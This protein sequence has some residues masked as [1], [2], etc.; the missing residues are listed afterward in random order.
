MLLPI[1]RY[2]S[3]LVNSV[4][5]NAVTIINAETGS[6]KSTQVCQYLQEAGYEVIVTEPRRIAA[7]TLADRV[8]EEIG[9]LDIV[10]YHT[11]FE[12]EISEKNE[13]LFCTDGLQLVKQL[14]E[15]LPKITRK[16]RVIIID[17]AHEW[18]LNIECLV[19]WAKKKLMEGWNTKIVITSATLEHEDL[20]SYYGNA[21]V[22]SIPGT[23]FPVTVIEAQACELVDQ[24]AMYSNMGKNVLVFLPGKREIEETM[25]EL[26]GK[27]S[28]IILPMH[29]ELTMTDQR[30]CFKEYSNSSKIVLATNIAQTSVTIPDIDVVV[31]SGTERRV[32]TDNGIQGIFLKDIS[33]ADCMQR[34]GRAGRTKNGI[35]VLCGTP[36]KSRDEFSKPEIQRLM[37][38]QM[39]LRLDS[40]G[41]D[42]SEMEFFHQPNPEDIL[43]AKNVLQII[44]AT[45]DNTITELGKKILEIPISVRHARMI[46]E[47]DKYGVVDDVITIAAILEIGSLI[48]HRETS[49][50]ILTSESE[51]D[52][53]AELQIWNTRQGRKIDFKKEG[54]FAK[55]F[56]RVKE[57]REK[58]IQCIEKN[59]TV[60]LGSTGNRKDIIRSCFMGM[61]DN[62]YFY[63]Y[64]FLQNGK[65]YD[66]FQFDNKS[67]VNTYNTRW[68]IGFPTRIEFKNNHGWNRHL[69]I[70]KSLTA[71]DS[72]WVEE[73]LPEMFTSETMDYG[74]SSYRD[75]V[76]AD[77]VK[78][79]G[80]ITISNETV[81]FP[82]HPEYDKL[83][84]EYEKEYQY[85]RTP[86]YYPAPEPVKKQSTIEIEGK[87]FN[88]E[89]Y[90]IWSNKAPVVN[91]GMSDLMEIKETVGAKLDNGK[92]L[93]FRF[94]SFKA[95]TIP[96]LIKAISRA[97]IKFQ[98]EEIQNHLP[99]LSS[100]KYNVIMD[101]L[102]P[103]TGTR[104]A[105]DM[106]GTKSYVYV[107]L[108]SKGNVINLS[109]E[110]DSDKAAALMEESLKV[111]IDTVVSSKYPVKKF[112]FKINGKMVLTPKG[113]KVYL[114]FLEFVNECK[115][116]LTT[117]NIQEY[118]EMIDEY[119]NEV[120]AEL[121]N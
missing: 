35:Y 58:I 118:V 107:S 117:S 112:Q 31:D 45:K 116:E 11:G 20:S 50:S 82:N 87:T 6:G 33:Q 67:C 81:E 88:V 48:N 52:L 96:L 113:N 104:E 71:I 61:L 39:V 41:V 10:G 32:E 51:S 86:S 49:Y 44:G 43:A 73:C 27:T 91:L 92:Q 53:L 63:S 66:E 55:N 100:S 85:Y 17:E 89:Y 38:D 46:I 121:G 5:E 9:D 109:V 24:A 115:G 2:K 70:L 97:E 14:A 54:L 59:N 60:T 108:K 74:Y 68:Y 98:L 119:Y 106:F 8:S 36:L 78:S 111:I 12:K 26:V 21:S 95:Q 13:I 1:A 62:V 80:N 19:G 105:I 84:S 101:E 69:D 4:N 77:V 3:Q 110:K 65:T 83:K 64:E 57:L 7:V 114:K 15:R 42:A 94:Q 93:E 30:A 120:I 90:S 23:I 16:P 76:T 103:H 72:S 34:K 75:C 22:L 37:L 28:A 40:V 29:G 102:L 79:F 47:A 18:N 99:K 56:F 25:T